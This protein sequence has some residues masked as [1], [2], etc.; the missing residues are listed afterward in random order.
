MSG[1]KDLSDREVEQMLAEGSTLGAIGERFGVSRQ[2]VTS[3]LAAIKRRKVRPACSGCERPDWPDRSELPGNGR[4]PLSWTMCVTCRAEHQ[5]KK[6][7]Q[8]MAKYRAHKCVC[9]KCGASHPKR[10]GGSK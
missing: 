3:R 4:P 8:K 5:G 10:R 9:P 7:R 1:L 2:A 6:E